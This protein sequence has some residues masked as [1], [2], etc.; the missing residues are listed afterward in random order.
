[1]LPKKIVFR[2]ATTAEVLTQIDLGDE[3]PA[4]YG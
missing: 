1:V 2:D 3:Y 4:R